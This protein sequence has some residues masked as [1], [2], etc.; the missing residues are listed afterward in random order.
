[1]T[2]AE[3]WC[4][5]TYI[6]MD[7]S[8]MFTLHMKFYVTHTHTMLPSILN[9]VRCVYIPDV[10]VL[11]VSEWVA[12]TGNVVQPGQE[13]TDWPGQQWWTG[14]H[15]LHHPL[16]HQPD[17]VWEHDCSGMVYGSMENGISTC[18]KVDHVCSMQD[19]TTTDSMYVDS[20][21]VCV[22]QWEFQNREWKYVRE[23]IA[24]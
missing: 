21:K 7:S 5:C 4:Q 6:F 15:G 24:V 3:K 16:W 18:N 9:S 8:W 11:H 14:C 10:W 23:G 17:Q 19:G 2:A 1:M 20:M 13:S 22:G 12:G